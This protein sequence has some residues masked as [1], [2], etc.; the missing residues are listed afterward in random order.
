MPQRYC[1]KTLV[2][3]QKQILLE[4][5]MAPRHYMLWKWKKVA[6]TKK[7]CIFL[8]TSL[9]PSHNRFW[10]QWKSSV[11]RGTFHF[12]LRNLS[13]RRLVSRLCISKL[14]NYIFAESGWNKL[15]TKHVSTIFIKDS[16]NMGQCQ[17]YTGYRN[18]AV[19]SLKDCR[20]A[21]ILTKASLIAEKTIKWP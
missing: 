2:C 11:L 8:W 18:S 20:R 19:R 4:E 1:S 6:V 12:L 9:E 7:F 3:K 5:I 13:K 10:N 17:K 16:K 14:K 21:F 15:K